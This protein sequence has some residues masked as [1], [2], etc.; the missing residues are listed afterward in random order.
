MFKKKKG[1]PVLY[2]S[3]QLVYCT[4]PYPV[5]YTRGCFQNLNPW[6]FSHV[7]T[8]LPLRQGSPSLII[9][10]ILWIIFVKILRIMTLVESKMLR[11]RIMVI[12]W[13]IFDSIK[14]TN[15]A[16]EL[17]SNLL[18]CQK[19]MSVNFWTASIWFYLECQKDYNE[20]L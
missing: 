7:T 12:L 13:I 19:L 16:I 10:F 15:S 9:M 20:S 4:Q 8:T 17:L 6:P 14:V 2:S 11:L 3:P 1:S 5:F 18:L